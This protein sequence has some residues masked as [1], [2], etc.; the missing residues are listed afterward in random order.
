MK[1]FFGLL[2]K[3]LIIKFMFIIY[4]LLLI[5]AAFPLL[6]TVWYIIKEK[7]IRQNGINTSGVVTHIHT[8]AFRKGPTVD[9][10]HIEFASV[11]QGHFHKSNITTK[12]RKFKHG[13]SVPVIY[14]P[15][16]P[17]KIVVE[18]KE[19]YGPMLLF[20][21]LIFLFTIFAVYKVEEMLKNGNI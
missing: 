11:I 15:D 16:E 14:L 1:S 4:I 2:I 19:G 5:I 7:R 18:G 10:V 13:E 9:I 6:K 17:S 12:H 3:H 20:S 8:T 21:I